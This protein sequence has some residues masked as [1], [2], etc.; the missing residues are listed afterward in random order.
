MHHA[1][2]HRGFRDAELAGGLAKVR[3]RG[4]LYA[5]RVVTEGD[6]IQ[7]VRQDLVLGQVL[8]HLGRHAH[9]AQLAADGALGR[10]G[11]LLVVLR[12]D[13]QQVVLD[14]LL[15]ESR[16]A[17]GHAAVRQVRGDGAEVALEIDAFVLV[18]AAILNGDDRV[19][20]RLRDLIRLDR[21]AALLVQVRHRVARG[22][23]HGGDLRGLARLQ[24]L[25]V[26]RHRRIRARDGRA[27]DTRQWGKGDGDEHADDHGSERD[28]S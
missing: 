22:V 5:E 13:Q 14:V 9:L 17:L 18:E 15:V 20:H 2:E 12:G 6:E 21:V 1:G 26:G 24:V 19:L 23:L 28:L 4:G 16:C 25:H 3:P 27:R 11:A 10:R 7:V 8:V